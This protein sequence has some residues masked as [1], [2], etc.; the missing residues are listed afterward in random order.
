MYKSIFKQAKWWRY[1]AWTLPFVA[2]ATLI[3]FEYFSLNNL[4]DIAV[5]TTIVVF[6]SVSVFWW[7]WAIDAIK[8]MFVLMQITESNFNDVKKALQ[9]TKEILRNDMGNRQ[10]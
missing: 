4:Y 10:R 2:L 6:F 7:W 3:G 8:K 5:I 9:E 1:A